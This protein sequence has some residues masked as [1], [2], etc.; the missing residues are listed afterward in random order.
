[1]PVHLRKGSDPGPETGVDQLFSKR[2]SATYAAGKNL[3]HLSLAVLKTLIP[4]GSVL[5]VIGQLLDGFKKQNNIVHISEFNKRISRLHLC[6][7]RFHSY[8][9]AWEK[10]STIS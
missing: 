9:N 4:H 6:M 2:S 5:N 8:T 1:V 7:N 10:N 3:Y